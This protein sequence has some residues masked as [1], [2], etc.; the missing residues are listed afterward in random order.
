[1]AQQ[2]GI[3]NRLFARTPEPPGPWGR[4]P[5]L[6]VRSMVSHSG[7]LS[8]A[9]HRGCRLCIPAFSALFIGRYFCGAYVTG[10]WAVAK[11]FEGVIS[12]FG[13]VVAS[14]G[15][16]FAYSD[17]LVG[18]LPSLAVGELGVRPCGSPPGVERLVLQYIS[19]LRLMGCIWRFCPFTCAGIHCHLWGWQLFP[20]ALHLSWVLEH[21]S[22]HV[23]CIVSRLCVQFCSSIFVTP[24]LAFVSRQEGH[25]FHIG[26]VVVGH[27]CQFL[28][29]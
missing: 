15:V 2:R 22:F 21:G 6:V 5:W 11:M 23:S 1:V 10:I 13:I 26:T 7:A 18:I 25:E 14:V 27:G 24:V 29:V 19:L 20:C 28:S 16:A 17:L 12:E 3:R 9:V 4:L 8:T